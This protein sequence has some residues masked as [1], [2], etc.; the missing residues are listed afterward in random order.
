MTI[1][2]HEL[3]IGLLCNSLTTAYLSLHDIGIVDDYGLG[4]K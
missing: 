1:D 2:V 3:F 4:G